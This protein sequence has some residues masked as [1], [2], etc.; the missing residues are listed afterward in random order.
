MSNI[1]YNY[2]KKLRKNMNLHKLSKL[3]LSIESSDGLSKVR[4]AKI[5]YFLHKELIRAGLSTSEDLGY[6]RMPLGPVPVG[7]MELANNC[8][9]ITLEK[10]TTGLFYDANVYKLPR[11]FHVSKDDD[12]DYQAV[13]SIL[14]VLREFSTSK[15]VEVSHLE[16]SWLKHGNSE[17]FYISNKDMS[18]I[19]PKKTR[20]NSLNNNGFEDESLQASLVSGM[21]KDI[22]DE[23]TDLEFPDDGQS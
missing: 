14:E 6:I 16:P 9:E 23:S 8:K 18:N 3:I 17:R 13:E 5:I 4:F 22:V 15:L 19:L 2:I 20:L 10:R 12:V 1:C 11:R 21:L 7:F